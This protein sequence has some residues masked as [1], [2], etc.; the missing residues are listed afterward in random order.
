[1]YLISELHEYVKTKNIAALNWLIDQK[2]VEIKDGKLFTTEAARV[3]VDKAAG[4]WDQRQLARKI[5][6]NSLYGAILNEG[7]RFYDKR[8]GQSVTITGRS[9][10]RHMNSKVNECI[11]G[12]YTYDGGGIIYADTD[13]SYFS[14]YNYLPTDTNERD[15]KDFMLELYLK[16]GDVVNESFPYFMDSAFNTGLDRGSIIAAGLELVANDGMFIKK[17]RYAVLKFWDESNG[18]LDENGK[19][20]KIKAMGLDL[21]RADTPKFMQ[22]FLSD[23]LM[24]ILTGVEQK[25]IMEQIKEF[26]N[27]FR[28]LLPWEQGTPK[29]VNGL[30]NYTEKL[31]ALEIKAKKS[32]IDISKLNVPKKEKVPGHVRA[33][34]NWNRLKTLY[35]DKQSSDI[36]DGGKVIV[37]KLKDNSHRITSIAYPYEQIHLPKWFTDLP[38]DTELM[39]ETIID[40]KVN[41]LIGVLGWD[42]KETRQDTFFD[43]LFTF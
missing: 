26:R 29:K 5:L 38:F 1:M 11:T 21:K 24:Q 9:I 7:C 2:L 42:L 32:N 15:D 17:K 18:R 28:S 37:C 43:D 27:K 4:F 30:S 12:E 20:G 3:E 14:A 6:L 25:I 35:S 10:A 31:D 40:K 41:N 33:A 16:I 23:I 36:L 34:I 22:D 13:S 39:E 19:P 8:I